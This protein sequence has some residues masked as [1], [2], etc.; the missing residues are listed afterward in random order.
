MFIYSLLA[1]LPGQALDSAAVKTEDHI[2]FWTTFRSFMIN[3]GDTP[4]GGFSPSLIEPIVSAIVLIGVL[5]S[6]ATIFMSAARKDADILSTLQK[7]LPRLLILGLVIFFLQNN[8]SNAYGFVDGMWKYRNN[9]T[10]QTAKYRKQSITIA[11]AI[12]NQIFDSR[13]GS[14]LR[15]QLGICNQ[16]PRPAVFL[17]S[18]TRP[19]PDADPQPTEQQ[20]QIYD[21]LEC[22]DTTMIRMEQR[23]AQLGQ[24]CQAQNG[25][26]CANAIAKSQG[27]RIKAINQTK[28]IRNY[29][30]EDIEEVL[31]AA[32]GGFKPFE[33]IPDVDL[34]FVAFD[35]DEPFLKSVR[36]GNWLFLSYLETGW[37][38]AGGFF[39]ITIAVAL[40]PGLFKVLADWFVTALSLLI[41]E[42]VYLALIGLV[43]I[44]AQSPELEDF[45]S[46]IFLQFLGTIGP[47]AA[48]AFGL[49][50]GWAMA[51]QYRGSATGLA[52]GVTSLVTGGG[53]A[54]A[55][56]VSTRKR[57][58][59]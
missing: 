23:L 14:E 39:P 8:Y 35:G 10:A 41:G 2:K 47:L 33:E 21:Y 48:T 42:N 55:S 18:P 17:S 20:S 19:G 11:Q 57:L 28:A 26:K 44:T 29:Y 22:L 12:D 51:R 25:N 15:L 53:L 16:K 9:I 3:A 50:S 5:L 49:G 36:A 58:R 27:L 34:G 37:S 13:Y 7:N 32:D 54:I 40:I 24:E 45:G 43:A 31:S 52:V 1:E 46:Q 4:S 6:A 38:L 30:H 59:R 56:A